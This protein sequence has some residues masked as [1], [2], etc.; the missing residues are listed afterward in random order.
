MRR[1]A[2]SLPSVFLRLLL[3]R[4]AGACAQVAGFFRGW[5]RVPVRLHGGAFRDSPGRAFSEA[6]V[7]AGAV[8]SVTRRRHENPSRPPPALPLREKNFALG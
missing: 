7:R 5:A 1:G 4:I 3:W 6:I 8:Q 2:V